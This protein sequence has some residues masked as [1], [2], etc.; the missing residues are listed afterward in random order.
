MITS[1]LKMTA[2][3]FYHRYLSSNHSNH[4]RHLHHY[5]QYCQSSKIIIHFSI[6]RTEYFDNQVL[7]QVYKNMDKNVKLHPRLLKYSSL[8]A[9]KPFEI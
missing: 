2:E 1:L 8:T 4:Y 9:I 7:S 3:L 5:P 6:K